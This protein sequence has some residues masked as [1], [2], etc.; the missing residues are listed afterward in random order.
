M[1]RPRHEENGQP[2]GVMT[3]P[4]SLGQRKRHANAMSLTSPGFAS[5][6][7][8]STP[9]LSCTLVVVGGVV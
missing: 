7:H 5:N 4:L 8:S 2:A 9:R 1:D 6:A 3:T